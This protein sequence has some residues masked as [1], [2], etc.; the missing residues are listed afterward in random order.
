MTH[1]FQASSQAVEW[2]PIPQGLGTASAPIPTERGQQAF[3]LAKW[4]AEPGTYA[5]PEGM[6]W[7]E[8]FV[9]YAGR[10]VLRAEGQTVALLPGVVI[11]VKK[12]VPYELEI[13]EALE[14]FAVVTLGG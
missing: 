10:G 9:V 11:D 8:T 12:G 4:R 6:G 13:L 7:S 1:Q 14:K 5:R 3:R 2:R